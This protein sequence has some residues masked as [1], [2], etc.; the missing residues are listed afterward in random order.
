MWKDELK[1][2]S[3]NVETSSEVQP[4]SSQSSPRVVESVSQSNR[5]NKKASVAQ[6]PIREK[7]RGFTKVKLILESLQIDL[8][9]G[10]R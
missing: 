6:E 8:S 10:D 4:G 2:D 1:N 5:G 3:V 9:P 7:V